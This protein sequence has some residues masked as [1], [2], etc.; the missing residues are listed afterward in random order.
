M[1]GERW[2]KL[3]SEICAASGLQ[4]RR[5]EERAFAARGLG[6]N[7]YGQRTTIN[8]FVIRHVST[9]TDTDNRQ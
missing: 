9:G 3:V 8:R 5:C 2:P 7:R 1:T 4:N 6:T